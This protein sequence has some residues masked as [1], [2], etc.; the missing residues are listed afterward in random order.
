VSQNKLQG[1]IDEWVSHREV[2]I[3]TLLTKCESPV[4]QMLAMAFFRGSPWHDI[5]WPSDVPG[6]S[7]ELGPLHVMDLQFDA[8]T[9]SA[10]KPHPHETAVPFDIDQLLGGSFCEGVLVAQHKIDAGPVTYRADFAIIEWL[11][12]PG[13]HLRRFAIE[14]DGHDF[15]ERTKEQ[16]ARDRSRDRALMN[17]GWTVLR[18]TGSEVFRDP[19]GCVAQVAS[20]WL[21]EGIRRNPSEAEFQLDLLRDNLKRREREQ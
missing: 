20:A 13:E 18:F 10:L 1:M 19:I 17:A 12:S 4:E 15:H 8:N 6:W 5:A 16:A 3:K 14:V 7:P 11:K 9:F 21:L 2:Y